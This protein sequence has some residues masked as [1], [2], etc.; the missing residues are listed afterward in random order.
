MNAD[1]PEAS[2]ETPAFRNIVV[3]NV[4]GNNLKRAMYF[5]GLPEMKIENVTLRNIK[6][7]AT[8]GA[9][10]RQTNGLIIDNVTI[11]PE[12]GEAFTIAPTVENI[13]RL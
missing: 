4:N 10:L 11:I 9:L 3:E 2:E 8:Q 13:Q 12:Q 7:T 6:M 1:A 5:N